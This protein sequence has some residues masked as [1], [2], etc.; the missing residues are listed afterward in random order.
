LNEFV[1]AQDV[2]ATVADLTDE[3]VII[4]ERRDRRSRAHAAPGAIEFRFA[5]NAQACSF[6]RLPET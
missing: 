3:E 2:R 1:P 4:E 6:D 5:E